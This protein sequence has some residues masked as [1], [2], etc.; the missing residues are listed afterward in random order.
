MKTSVRSLMFLVGTYYFLQ[1]MGGNPG[2]HNQALKKFLKEVLE[3]SPV[4]SAAFFAVLVIPWMI[5]PVYGLISDFLPI[6]RLR[7]KSYFILS[8][9]VGAAAYFALSFLGVTQST[10]LTLLFIAAVGF[11]FS[12]V[13]CDAVMIEKGQPLN[14]TSRLQSAQWFC[15]GSAGVIV[16]LSKGYIAEYLSLQQAVMISAVFP[17][18]VILFTLVALKEEPVQS[19]GEAAKQAWGGLKIA[20]KS[21]T[22]WGAAVFLFLFQCNPN[23]GSAFYYYEKDVLKFSE[24]L[25]GWIDSVGQIFFVIG[26]FLFAVLVKR[27]SHE[28]LLR[29]IIISG[30][31]GNL[32]FL[33]FRDATSA[34]IVVSIGTTISVIAF[35][36]ILTLAAKACPK[37]AEGVVF[38]LMMSLLNFGEKFGEIAG[39]ALYERIGYSWLVVIGAACTALMWLFLPLV[40]EKPNIENLKTS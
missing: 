7:R 40:R 20:I 34:F 23:L 1:A 13:L 27:W 28:T 12:D 6:F 21:K 9:I 29:A 38:A 18:L 10:V 31:I 15:L 2:L 36:G 11:A 8:S 19:S 4:E 25:I 16:A 32:L 30:V 39:S 3:F 35:L 26:T 5:K 33:F 14:A 37:H 24:V 17:V 22:L